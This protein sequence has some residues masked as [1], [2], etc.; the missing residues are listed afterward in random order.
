MTD[1]WMGTRPRSA[2][3]RR[4]ALV[5]VLTLTTGAVDA[6]TYLRLG[7]V[8]SSVITGNL[9]LLG[10]A[11]GH[12]YAPIAVSGGLALGGYA[13]G[14]LVGGRIAGIPQPDQLVWPAEVTRALRA[15]LL[16][17][18]VFTGIW[19]GSG[20][21]RAGTA[22][23][24]LLVIAAASMGT[25]SAAV[26]RLGQ[27]SS[28]YLTST[29]SGLLTALALHRWPADWWRSTGTLLAIVPGAVAGAITV[30]RAPAWLPAAVLAPLAVVLAVSRGAM[31]MPGSR[32]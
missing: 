25:Q 8:F 11:A 23:M 20:Y 3:R 15:E 18:L 21:A 19:Y 1:G 28:T 24:A 17:L 13:T 30:T 14:I 29:L 32:G 5:V 16:I 31:F 9:V 7:H 2:E 6:A 10:T 22:R 26:R 4:N 12:D 27:M